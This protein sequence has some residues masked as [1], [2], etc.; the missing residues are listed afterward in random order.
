M[1][2]KL[3]WSLNLFL[4]ISF[5]WLFLVQPLLSHKH[6]TSTAR[7]HEYS[8][9]EES[10]LGILAACFELSK[11]ETDADEVEFDKSFT[12]FAVNFNVVLSLLNAQEH[13]LHLRHWQLQQG[14]QHLPLFLLHSIFRI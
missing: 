5:S 2:N 1:R 7:N 4:L 11:E 12:G 14:V 3:T 9:K 6:H 10:D 13:S 8:A